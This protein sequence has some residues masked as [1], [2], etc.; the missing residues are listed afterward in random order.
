MAMFNIE[1]D[2]DKKLVNV[3]RFG[4]ELPLLRFPILN[5]T[6]KVLLTTKETKHCLDNGVIVEEVFDDGVVRLDMKNY[7]KDN[8]KA[9]RYVELNLAKSQKAIAEEAKKKAEE[10]AKKKAEEEAAKKAAEEEA[11]KKAEEEAKKK[12]EEEAKKKAEA[13]AAAKK[14]AEE[15]AKKKAAEEAAKKQNQQQ[16]NNGK[17]N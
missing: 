3:L 2:K 9:E 10:E 11:K 1:S 14:A 15:E 4:K 5:N 7:D 17:K 13:E 12:A 8:S 16:N 6:F